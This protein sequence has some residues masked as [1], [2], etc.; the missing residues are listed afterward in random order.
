MFEGLPLDSV[1]AKLKGIL[2]ISGAGRLAIGDIVNVALEGTVVGV[3]H[4]HDK[5]GLLVRTHLIRPETAKL[6]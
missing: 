1:T 3:L 6:S 2:H 5:D 4:E